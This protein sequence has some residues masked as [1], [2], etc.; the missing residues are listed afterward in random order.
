MKRVGRILL[1]SVLGLVLALLL[2]VAGGYGFLQ[3]KSGKAWLAAT[4]A[5][6]LSTPGSKVAIDGLDRQRRPSSCASPPSASPT[7]MG[8]GSRFTMSSS[9]STAP[10]FC[11]ASSPSGSCGPQA[12]EVTRQPVAEPATAA[13]SSSL[14]LAA[15]RLPLDVVIDDLGIES[16][17]LA[18]AVLGEPVKLDFQGH[19]PPRPR[20]GSRRIWRCGAP[21]TSPVTPSWTSAS[22]ASLRCSI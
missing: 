10:R 14:D 16:V 7:A 4:L 19:G 6:A 17:T 3:T 1:Y 21:T 20:G 2:V 15:P 13:T 5:Q 18:P 11:A 12:R 8:P 9:R 22:T